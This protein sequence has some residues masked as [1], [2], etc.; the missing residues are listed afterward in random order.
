MMGG[1]VISMRRIWW[2]GIDPL[3]VSSC[4]TKFKSRNAAFRAAKID[5][6]IPMSQQPSKVELVL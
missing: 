6:G 5:A 2:G 3:G 1:I 4:S